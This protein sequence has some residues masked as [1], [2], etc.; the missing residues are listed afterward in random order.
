M[1]LSNGVNKSVYSIYSAAAR[2]W[3][4][5]VTKQPQCIY[6]YL[7]NSFMG[8]LDS[9]L[10]HDI[11][12]HSRPLVLAW[13]YEWKLSLRKEKRDDSENSVFSKIAKIM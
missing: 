8:V 7:V 12:Q 3:L 13:E 11:S 2:V 10:A 1:S 4:G 5:L 6:T 9:Q